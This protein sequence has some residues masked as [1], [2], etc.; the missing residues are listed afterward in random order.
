MLYFTS[1][2]PNY[3]HFKFFLSFFTSA[4]FELELL[5][6]KSSALTNHYGHALSFYLSQVNLNGTEIFR[7]ERYGADIDYLK[8]YGLEYL[9]AVKDN[10][11][12]EFSQNHPR[13]LYQ[14]AK[15]GAI[16][17]EELK[18]KDTSLRSTLLEVT[19]SCPDVENF[20]KLSKKLPQTMTIQKLRL[21]I[22]RL[23]NQ[24]KLSGVTAH[25]LVMLVSSAKQPEVQV[26]LDN[27]MRDLFF[28][29]V[30][31]GDTIFVKW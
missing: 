18:K 31:N 15:Y 4:D 23:L 21:L 27:D 11:L 24:K 10:K 19:I 14:V 3:G 12:A 25:K 29:S 9:A 30:D 8:R 1:L 6:Y 7:T 2:C 20:E 16:E 22:Q 17:E 13:Y 26:P 5:D 28:Y